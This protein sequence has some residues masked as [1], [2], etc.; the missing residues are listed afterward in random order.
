MS[1]LNRAILTGVMTLMLVTTASAQVANSDD[2]PPSANSDDTPPSANSDDTPP[3]VTFES[4]P[5]SP[6]TESN[7]LIALSTNEDARVEYSVDDGF[8]TDLG[9]DF[10]QG[11][12]FYTGELDGGDHT[13]EVRAEDEAGNTQT[14]SF[15]FKVDDAPPSV[16]F[17]STPDS[18]TTES[19]PL[20]AL[21]TNEDARVEYSVDDGFFTDLGGDFRQGFEFYTGELDGGDHT[22]EVRAEDEAGN[23][24]TES[25]SFK[26]AD[27]SEVNFTA[28]V[29]KSYPGS[30]IPI[31]PDS[32]VFDRDADVDFDF[33]LERNGESYDISNDVNDGVCDFRGDPG[34]Q[35]G[36]DYFCGSKV[37][38]DITTG[39]AYELVAEWSL[40]GE[41]YTRVLD[42]D[43]QISNT[44]QWYSQSTSHGGRVRNSVEA[45]MHVDGESVKK[46]D[47]TFACSGS[48]YEIDNIGTVTAQCSNGVTRSG[49]TPP[50]VS[51]VSRPNGGTVKRHNDMF[52]DPDCNIEGGVSRQDLLD[53]KSNQGYYPP[54]CDIDWQLGGDSS[55]TAYTFNE[56]GEYSVAVDYVN[57]VSD[58]PQYICPAD[59]NNGLCSTGTLN[60]A[61]GWKNL[62]ERTV[63]IIEPGVEIDQFAFSQNSVKQNVNGDTYIR[64]KDYNGAI[65]GTIGVKNTGT[66]DI[67]I[68]GLGFEC[69]SG[70]SC[71]TITTT[72]LRI[73]EENTALINWK[74]DVPDVRTTG[75][76][77]VTV[78]YEDSYGIGCQITEPPTRTYYLDEA[79]PETDQGVN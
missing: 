14:D 43:F 59:S 10:R 52:N 13:V 60:G 4:T 38:T 57:A 63:S 61:S 53:I 48:A 8:F 55:F 31:D 36:A 45:N 46:P 65:T 77:K 58:S 20:I 1:R 54:G 24:Q 69:P 42:G 62:E 35:L 50:V 64:R 49:K 75:T 15:S 12:E 26:V 34:W 5:D 44:A 11:F 17:E 6:T 71:E 76:I 72:D 70:V 74:A 78:Q 18:P 79:D 66:G 30:G 37:P 47:K 16:T 21:S 40:R 27:G 68:T 23:T 22:V 3:S 28:A 41:S 51:F 19:N 7:P 33:S 9:G 2:T 39:A 56:P 25:F 67:N 29:D 32:D 73:T